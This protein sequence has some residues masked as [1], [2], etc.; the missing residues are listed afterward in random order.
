MNPFDYTGPEFLL[1][2]LGLAALVI[3]G[4]VLS[5]QYFES[6][7]AP[8]IDLSDP[9]LI[10]YLRGG[11]VAT[12]RVATFSLIDRGLLLVDGSSIKRAENVSPEAVRRPIEKLLLEKFRLPQE[13]TLIYQDTALKEACKPYAQTL[14]AARLLPDE[15]V[16]QARMIRLVIACFVL[17]AV[18]VVKIIIAL[19]RGRTNIG[20]LVI[21][22]IVAIVVAVAI[23][24]PRLTQAGKA[25]LGDVQN[26]YSGL[27]D[28]A[29]LLQ[30]GGATIEPLMVAAAF[31]LHELSGTGFSYMKVLFPWG[32]TSASSS[33]ASTSSC[34]SSCSSSCGSS[35]GGGCGGGCGGCGS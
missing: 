6:T 11:E 7:A 26:L 29:F 14:R 34:N 19:D 25:M 13:S 1:F 21:L 32:A 10:A 16:N 9:Y 28:R 22:M 3:I 5:R 27:R 12:M 8:K 17:S 33:C 15:S 2:Y 4:L 24:F 18:A 30:P 23:S 20:F 31:G 35:C